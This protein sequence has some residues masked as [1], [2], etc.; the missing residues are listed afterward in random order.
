[1]EL[2][3]EYLGC[4]KNDCVMFKIKDQAP[5]WKVKGT[6]CNHLGI[7]TVRDE[8][9]GAK[10][11]VCEVSGCIYFQNA[12]ARGLVRKWADFEMATSD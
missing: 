6:L 12:K 5:C 3:Y 11:T 7:E 10:E 9:P 2:C 8:V 4:T 1:M